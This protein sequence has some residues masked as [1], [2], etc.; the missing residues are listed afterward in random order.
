MLF[1]LACIHYFLF[2]EGII[3]LSQFLQNNDK[4]KESLQTIRS[5]LCTQTE[6]SNIFTIIMEVHNFP[7]TTGVFSVF[8]TFLIFE[9]VIWLNSPHHL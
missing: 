1:V 7:Y 9:I 8:K 6:I 5:T 3:Y 2:K 4:F